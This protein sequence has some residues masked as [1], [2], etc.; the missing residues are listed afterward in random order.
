MVAETTFSRLKAHAQPVSL[1]PVT[2]DI[3]GLRL[4]MVNTYLIGDPAASDHAWVLVD[5]GLPYSTRRILT[6][7]HDRF[8][9]DKPPLAIVL[10][11]GHF[12]HVGSVKELAEYWDVP[13]Y[14]HEQELPYLTGRENYP[15]PDPTVGG[16]M[17]AYMASLYPYKG[18]N[19]GDRVKPLPEDGRVP[20]LEHWRWVHTPGHTKGHVSLFRDHD[21]VLI[22][23]NAFVTTNPQSSLSVLT[24]YPVIHGPPTYYTTDWAMA[25]ESVEKLAHLMSQAAATGH[26]L[27]MYGEALEAGL[28][29]LAEDF[30][31]VAV[32]KQG[33]YVH[34]YD[35]DRPEVHS[36]FTTIA[37]EAGPAA[38]IGL[39]VA[40]GAA[41][42]WWSMRSRKRGEH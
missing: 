11:H 23:G 14:A 25:K 2:D 22:A 15:P 4:F 30:D 3:V 31:K 39:G 42:A 24:Q 12:D 29:K 35:P 10:T 36:A 33:H 27:P 34:E 21:R 9:E 8:G 41:A 7:A 38:L 13:V 1:F 17:M 40:A 16:G 19:L 32:P 37:K 20:F 5:T 18:I 28:Q 6:A 26:G